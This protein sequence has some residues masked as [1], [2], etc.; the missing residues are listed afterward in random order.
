MTKLKDDSN[1]NNDD[2][3]RTRINKGQDPD[4]TRLKQGV[5]SGASQGH[6][7]RTGN[8][9]PNDTQIRHRQDSTRVKPKGATA[10]PTE[11][12]SDNKEAT[13]LKARPSASGPRDSGGASPFGNKPSQSPPSGLPFGSSENE[14]PAI[15]QA[16]PIQRITLNKRFVLDETLGVGGMGVVYKAIDKRKVE[17]KD[18]NPYLAVKILSDDFRQHPDAFMALQREAR[19]S[20]SIAHPN[21]VNVHDFDRDGDTVFMTMEYME[22]TPLDRLLREHKGVGLMKEQAMR[23]LKDMCAALEHAHKEYIIHADF[24]PGNIFVTNSGVTKVFDFGIARAVAQADRQTQHGDKSVFDPETLGALTPAYASPE[25][26]R[27]AAPTIQDDVFALGCVIYEMFTGEHPFNRVPADQAMDQKI[28]P[29]RVKALTGQQ[30]KALKRTL[31]LSREERTSSVYEFLWEFTREKKSHWKQWLAA[32]VLMAV[33]A[34]VYMQY[35]YKKEL[36][37][38]ELKAQLA[39]Q[40]KIDLVKERLGKLLADPKFTALWESELWE[41]V[42]GGRKVLGL[43]DDWLRE[44]ETKI[45]GLYLTQI[46]QSRKKQRF[47]VAKA[48][49][50][51]AGRYRGYEDRLD[52]E[53]TALNDDIADIREQQRLAREKKRREQELARQQAAAKAKQATAQKPR[54]TTPKPKPREKRDVFE[55]AMNNVKQQL[56]CTH[57]IN[58]SNLN[59]AVKQA[60]SIDAKKFRRQSQQV[61][62]SLAVCIEKIGRSDSNRAEDLKVFALGLFP[63]NRRLTRISIKPVDPCN[64]RMAGLGARGKKGTCRDRFFNGGYGPRMVVVPANGKFGS[65]AISQYEISVRQMNEYCRK[66]GDC[67]VQ[68]VED[69]NLPVTNISFKQAKN[70]ARWLSKNSGYRYRIPR[71]SEWLYAASANGSDLDANRNCTLESRGINKGETLEEITTGKKNKWGL[72]NY[73]GNAQEWVLKNNRDLFAAGGAHTDPFRECTVDKE[74]PHNGKPDAITGFR[75]LRELRG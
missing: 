4:A 24:K 45:V 29:K 3:D 13:R 39:Q 28:K 12:R 51:H 72:V 21:I 16:K 18:R 26:L 5:H 43:E 2:P 62:S 70:Y 30:W 75:L 8:A 22:G 57:G 41:Q 33:G 46:S 25:M 50:E 44:T 56:R 64:P 71:R 17:A 60:R 68:K 63:G 11:A 7:A 61:V 59:V 42:Q 36:S 58:T 31:A 27:G 37:P 10:P 38:E 53:R 6:Q 1:Q 73:V 52:R 69:Q 23:I 47:S 32:A 9:N 54:N 35:F 20:Q 48:Y 49:L 74:R 67:K 19:K 40:I 14:A 65:F 34:G 66:T 15:P 55:L